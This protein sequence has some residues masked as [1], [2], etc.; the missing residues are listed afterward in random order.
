MRILAAALAGAVALPALARDV[1]GVEFAETAAV[2]GQ[3]LK[4]NGAGVRKKLFIKVYAGGL[5]LAAPS[6]D[7]DAI[8]AADAP[9]R[10]RMVFLRDVDRKSILGAFREGFENNSAAQAAALV[11]KLEG[12]G[13]AI[14]DVK[15]RGEIVVTYL[16]GQGTTVTGPGGT[17][18][19]EGKDFA[20]ALFR[21]WL[22][23]KPADDDLKKKMLGH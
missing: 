22:G 15:S 9:R 13:P 8:V 21:N 2:A 4:L 10:V 11:P 17:A 19:V 6:S 3:E 12:I 14:G 16:P 7:A 20:D 23:P 18:T 5:Y 1:A